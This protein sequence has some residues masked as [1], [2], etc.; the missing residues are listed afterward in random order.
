MSVNLLLMVGIFLINMVDV[1]RQGISII[2]KVFTVL[3]WKIEV[4]ICDHK[5]I[6]FCEYNQKITIRNNDIQI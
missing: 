5:R 1:Y 3:G 6:I 4:P 2:Y